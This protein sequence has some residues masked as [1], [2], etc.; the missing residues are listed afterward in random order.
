M[1]R[2]TLFIFLLFY[3]I[4]GKGQTD[5]TAKSD[6]DNYNKFLRTAQLNELERIAERIQNNG[7]IYFDPSKFQEYGS[8]ENIYPLLGINS[9]NTFEV[10]KQTKSRFDN[11][12]TFIRYQQ[13]YK[14]IKVEGGGYTAGYIIPDGGPVGPH[15]PC[16]QAYMVAPYLLTDINI[17]VVPK[18]QKPAL[19]EILNIRNFQQASLVIEQN[20]ERACAYNLVWKVEYYNGKSLT[21]WVDALTGRVLK[22]LESTRYKMAPTENYGDQD[23]DD[24]EQ[25]NQTRLISEDG[26]VI[27]YDFNQAN[28]YTLTTTDYVNTLIPSSNVNN[29][30][31]TTDAPSNVFQAHWVTTTTANIFKSL[32]IEYEQLHVGANCSNTDDFGVERPNAGA[33]FGST[34]ENGFIII[35]ETNGNSLAEFDIIGHELGHVFLN[36]FLD[37]DEGGNASLHEG[38]A[39]MLGVYV[40][41]VQNGGVLDWE[42]GDD[43]PF[44][45]RDLENPTFNCFDDVS[46]FS[47][48]DRHVRSTPLGHWFF[49]ASTGG[50]TSIGVLN[51]L[52]IVLEALNLVSRDSDYEDLMEATLTVAEENFGKCSSEFAAINNAWENICVETEL[53]T[54]NSNPC[55]FDI[56]GPSWVC[57]ESN[58]AKFCITGGIPN[59]FWKWTII[60]K[61]STDYTSVNGMQGNGQQGGQCLTLIDFPKYPYYPQYITIKVWSNTN[62]KEVRKRVKLVDC[63]GDDPT[64]EEYYN[65]LF[66][67]EPTIPNIAL[68]RGK[69]IEELLIEA[70][71]NPFLRSFDISITSQKP[72]PYSLLLY[73]VQGKIVKETQG[74]I[75][76]GYNLLTIDNLEHLKAGIYL[77]KLQTAHK[78][79]S[80]RIVKL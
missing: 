28:L 77:Y 58:Y 2:I 38:I 61:K 72:S 23:M 13:Y 32:D 56:S 78:T 43:V 80:N 70:K 46:G 37:Y 60:G 21:S 5:F 20:L 74:N 45:V 41:M 34:L 22:T 6:C 3:A 73:D 24:S 4:L 30:W 76:E 54:L 33:L 25:G 52:Q 12:R 17:N 51:T 69:P 65:S 1:K 66:R 31:T 71:P 47:F 67:S 53:G 50:S 19:S 10:V 7:K 15:D 35:G 55:D 26:S 62:Q 68:S 64:C 14:N 27:T 9:R 39:D 42:M 57:E 59:N 48:D 11:N 29:D 40:E 36:E 49:Q 79:I 44:I 16:L 63:N 8:I 18:I 75:Q